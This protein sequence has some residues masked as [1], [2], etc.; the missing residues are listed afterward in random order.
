VTATLGKAQWPA[1]T[2]IGFCENPEVNVRPATAEDAAAIGSILNALLSTTSIEWTD[3]PK[4]T[5]SVMVW[6]DE[7]ETVLVA[8]EHEEVVGLAAYGW[9]RNAAAWPGYRFTVEN[10]VHVREDH[11]GT[12]VGR[13]LMLTLIDSARESGKHS[14]IAAIDGTNEASI[15]FHQRL[16]FTEVGRMPEIGAKFGR[17]CDLVLLQKRL[18]ERTTPP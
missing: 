18:D 3:T 5:A 8:E 16:G 13:N 4:T 17:W 1:M 14:M 9:F 6:M 12:G 7:H 2:L 11:W 10:T 15:R